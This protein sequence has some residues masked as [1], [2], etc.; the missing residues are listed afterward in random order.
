MEKLLESIDK[1]LVTDNPW[2]EL[3]GRQG[4][5]CKFCKARQE[6]DGKAI[7]RESCAWAY[8]KQFIESNKTKKSTLE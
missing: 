8:L 1:V 5:S 2:V 7:H 4:L 3:K 6:G